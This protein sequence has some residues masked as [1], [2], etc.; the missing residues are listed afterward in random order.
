MRKY[1]QVVDR[2]RDL[3]AL[4][5][6]GHKPLIVVI[7]G[8]T[9]NNK[10]T[11]EDWIKIWKARGYRVVVI[12]MP[13]HQT[14]KKLRWSKVCQWPQKIHEKLQDIYKQNGCVP[15]KV[16]CFSIS[17]PCVVFSWIQ[18]PEMFE[19]ICFV[20]PA[21]ELQPIL[22]VLQVVG[23]MFMYLPPVVVSFATLVRCLLSVFSGPEWQFTL[24]SLAIWLSVSLLAL[25]F[26]ATRRLLRIPKRFQFTPGYTYTSYEGKQVVHDRIPIVVACQ[27]L[28][29]QLNIRRLVKKEALV[30]IAGSIMIF[31]AKDWVVN[32][33]YAMNLVK[34]LEMAKQVVPDGEHNVLLDTKPEELALMDE[35]APA[36][37][38]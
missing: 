22:V 19:K 17:A 26:I 16:A 15:F 25:V 31:G 23:L 13:D 27:L 35:F 20:N 4:Q 24:S 14:P 37:A 21:F 12:H 34:E 11:F 18:R 32:H 6:K 29:L 7:T 28:L 38:V 2:R 8:F 30:R 9:E 5:S 36:L 3:K 33:R 1:F 10:E